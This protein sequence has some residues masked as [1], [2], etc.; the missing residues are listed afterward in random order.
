MGFFFS[1]LSASLSRASD[2]NPKGK[3]ERKKKLKCRYTPD[4]EKERKKA[5]ANT[6]ESKNLKCRYTPDTEKEGKKSNK[7][8]ST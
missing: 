3:D 7:A 4:T 6:T 2:Q 1:S 5:M 8:I